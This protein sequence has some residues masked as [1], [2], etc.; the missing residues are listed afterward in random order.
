M[1]I[2]FDQGT[3]AP[4][5]YQ[6]QGHQVM[7]A[8]E[9]GWSTL[10]NGELLSATEAAGFEVFVTTD[11]N[12]RYQ[13][14]LTNRKIALIVLSTTSWPRIQ[15]IADQVLLALLTMKVGDYLEMD[16]PW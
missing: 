9:Q 7:L 3:P 4:L 2:L 16:V 8:Y 10:Q 13:Q 12:L 15:K 14:N 11:K 5:R 1:R 6:L